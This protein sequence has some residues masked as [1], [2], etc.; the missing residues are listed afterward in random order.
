MCIYTHTIYEPHT[1]TWM[2]SQKTLTLKRGNK[3]AD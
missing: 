1:V 3:K 2:W